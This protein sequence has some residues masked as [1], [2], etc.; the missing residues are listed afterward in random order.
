MNFK[1]YEIKLSWMFTTNVITFY[2]LIQLVLL[3]FHH[4]VY[5]NELKWSK[6]EYFHCYYLWLKLKWLNQN[7]T[8]WLWTKFCFLFFTACVVVRINLYLHTTCINWGNCE[9]TRRVLISNWIPNFEECMYTRSWDI[10]VLS[11]YS[12][13]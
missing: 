4:P 2:K 11:C 9:F 3:K 6:E 12:T 10:H 1:K 7:I 5:L 8:N 13:W